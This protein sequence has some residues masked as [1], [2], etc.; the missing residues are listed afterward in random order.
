MLITVEGKKSRQVQ[1]SK[2][3]AM[4]R[5]W[6]E[7]DEGVHKRGINLRQIESGL[8]GHLTHESVTPRTESLTDRRMGA[9]RAE[10]QISTSCGR[11]FLVSQIKCFSCTKMPGLFKSIPLPTQ[12]SCK[13]YS[14]SVEFQGLAVTGKCRLCFTDKEVGHE[15]TIWGTCSFTYSRSIVGLETSLVLLGLYF[16]H[17]TSLCTKHVCSHHKALLKWAEICSA[18]QVSVQ[19]SNFWTWHWSPRVQAARPGL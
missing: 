3:K 9:L 17:W 12:S 13:T 19:E 8:I 11:Q 18:N 5:Q 10:R 4:T 16:I 1:K 6:H 2:E 14:F 7:W 15:E